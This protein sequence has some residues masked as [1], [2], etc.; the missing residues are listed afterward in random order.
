MLVH[1]LVGPPHDEA[2][3]LQLCSYNPLP[4][5]WP[6][7]TR[8]RGCPFLRDPPSHCLPLRGVSTALRKGLIGENGVPIKFCCSTA[9][10][11][12]S[13]AVPEQSPH[14]HA[15]GY[16]ISMPSLMDRPHLIAPTSTIACGEAPWLHQE[17]RTAHSHANC[18]LS[19]HAGA[20]VACPPCKLRGLGGQP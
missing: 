16:R 2:C 3:V 9:R 13:H 18:G 20:E 15:T 10:P 6:T 1:G 4:H 17:A 11:P 12:E 7:S 19:V 5:S 8:G 14:P